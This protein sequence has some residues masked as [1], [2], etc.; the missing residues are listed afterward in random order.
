MAI[1]SLEIFCSSFDSIQ[2]FQIQVSFSMF[3]IQFKVQDSS[4]SSASSNTSSSAS[5]L[6]SSLESSR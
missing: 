3:Q 4:S 1:Q 6:E 2:D 5:S